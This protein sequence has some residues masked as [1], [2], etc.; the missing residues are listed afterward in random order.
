[1]FKHLEYLGQ[2]TEYYE[3]GNV[4]FTGTFLKT[5]YFFYKARRYGTG[6]LYYK[7]GKLRYEGTFKGLKNYEFHHGLEY[8]ENGQ[9]IMHGN[10]LL[11]SSDEV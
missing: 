3:N 7:T 2:G 9:V 8:Q 10:G 1:M 5:P 6:K 11:E 4:S